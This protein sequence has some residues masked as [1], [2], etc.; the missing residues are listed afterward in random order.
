MHISRRLLPVLHLIAPS[1]TQL[2]LIELCQLWNTMAHS[3]GGVVVPF[4]SSVGLF[5]VDDPAKVAWVDV[6]GQSGLV[7]MQLVAYE[8]HL[9][10]QYGVVAAEAQVV[11]IRGYVT[12]DLG[13]I[14]IRANLHW[15]LP[16][17]H[18]HAGGGT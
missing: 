1:A 3:N 17:D 2:M 13:G 5:P 6:T 8:V 18:T 12:R 14:V 16:G 10:G 4:E 15:E 7:T 9:A 11:G